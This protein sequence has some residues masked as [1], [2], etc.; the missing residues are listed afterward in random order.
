MT[1]NKAWQEFGLFFSMGITGRV[2]L[3]HFAI[4]ELVLVDCQVYVDDVRV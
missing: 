3:S 4:K 1:R 2:I